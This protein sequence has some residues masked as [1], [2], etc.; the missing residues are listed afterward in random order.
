MQLEEMRFN[1]STHT[2]NIKI[3]SSYKGKQACKST[4]TASAAFYE[5]KYHILHVKCINDADILFE[6]SVEIFRCCFGL[7]RSLFILN[8][9]ELEKE[10]LLILKIERRVM[11][12]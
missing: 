5:E 10:L 12:K 4:Q 2:H 1:V 11:N 7:S 3:S 9:C 8:L 6:T